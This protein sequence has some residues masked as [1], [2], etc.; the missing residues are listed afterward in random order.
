MMRVRK[1]A[2]LCSLWI[3]TAGLLASGCSLKKDGDFGMESGEEKHKE[4][5][6]R[7]EV[8]RGETY[9]EETIHGETAGE[10]TVREQAEKEQEMREEPLRDKKEIYA[11]DDETSVVTMYLTIRTGNAEDHTDHTWTEI[12]SFDTYYY[13]ENDL[14]RYNCEAI[15]QIG[16]ESGPLEGEFGYGET[17]PNATVQIRG[18][19]SSRREQKNYK[20][21]IKKGKG[22]WRGQRTLALNKHIGDPVRFRNKLAYDLMKDIPQMMSARTQFVHLYVKDETAGGNGE[23]TDYGLFTQVE[24]MNQTYLKAHG[25][26]GRGH[27]Y[28]INFF[29]WNPYD[30]IRLKSDPEYDAKAFE[31]YIE[32]KGNDD[33]TKLLKTLDAVWDYS[34]PTKELIETYFDSEN[35]CYWMAFQILIGNYDAGS[36]NCYLYSPLHSKKW[37]FLSWDNDS[38]FSRT[39]YRLKGYSE[40]LSWERG[41]TQFLHVALFERMFKEECYREELLAAADDLRARYLNRELMEKRVAAYRAVVERYA[42][43]LPDGKYIGGDLETFFR[44]TE[45]IPAEVDENYGYLL[46]SMEKPWPFFVGVPYVEDGRLC[47]EWDVAYDVDHEEI[48]YAV[49]L[50]SDYRYETVIERQEGLRLPRTSFGP[51]SPGDYYLKVTARNASGY[52]QECYD[53]Y[54]RPDGGGKAYGT[55]AFTIGQDGQVERRNP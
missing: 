34:I 38:A 50:A 11:D 47:V 26:D 35:I 49:A 52:E 44:L 30:A 27:L 29:E 15:L 5:T 48:T 17:T 32:I 9:Q 25:L 36:R 42:F 33:H 41:M 54:S 28:K 8:G 4:E 23:F 1:T 2:L 45:A 22:A 40:G 3:L 14:P 12:N 53:F 31:E 19:T 6:S 43:A 37:Y 24:Q 46:E 10:G 20:V 16:D 13:S 51:V 39:A 7:E 55:V 21:R 18:Q